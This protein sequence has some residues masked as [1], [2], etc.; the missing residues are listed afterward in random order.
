MNV[1]RGLCNIMTLIDTNRKA[2]TN[3]NGDRFK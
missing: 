3:K 2:K 1:D